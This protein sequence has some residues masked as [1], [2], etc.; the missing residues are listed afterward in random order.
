VHTSTLR[1]LGGSIAVT[2]PGPLVKALG[3][4]AG[5]QVSFTAEGNGLKLV[6]VGR[7]KYSLEDVLAMQGGKPLVKDKAWDAMPAV[8]QEV[9]L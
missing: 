6:P 5:A 4:D 7:R 8:G 3:L 1:S 9:S 2:I